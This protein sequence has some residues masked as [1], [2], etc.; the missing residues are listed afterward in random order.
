MMPFARTCGLVWLWC[1]GIAVASTLEHNSHPMEWVRKAVTD[2][3][4]SLRFDRSH[5]K[6]KYKK[7][8][9]FTRGEGGSLRLLS[10]LG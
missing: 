7:T 9:E 1:F 2:F 6:E 10:L 3:G 4:Q 5:S 8:K